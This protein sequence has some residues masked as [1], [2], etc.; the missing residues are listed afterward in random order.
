MVENTGGTPWPEPPGKP[1]SL[2]TQWTAR[3]HIG[4]PTPCP[5]TA[6]P[7]Q[8]VEVGGR[9]SQPVLTADWPE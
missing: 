6:D 7:L 1:Q 8:R 3:D 4:A 9:W 2:C 5:Y